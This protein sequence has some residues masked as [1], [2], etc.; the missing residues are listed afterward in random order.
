MNQ[1]VEKILDLSFITILFIGAIMLFFSYFSQVELMIEVAPFSQQDN[2]LST[3][4][5][6]HHSHNEILGCEVYV[7][8]QEKEYGFN[9]T[10]DNVTYNNIASIQVNKDYFLDQIYELNYQK[11]YQCNIIGVVLNSVD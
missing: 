9:V 5:G 11:D 8:L 1:N 7:M 3:M 10:I 4:A 6:Y 2:H